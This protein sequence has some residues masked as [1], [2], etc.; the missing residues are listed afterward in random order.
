MM[1]AIFW[2]ELI[3][4]IALSAFF[5]GSEMAFS[6]VNRLRLEGA[7]EHG[8]KRAKLALRIYD[9]FESTLSA[10]LIGNNLVNIASSSTA[11]VMAIT[12]FGVGST[13]WV[14]TLLTITIIIFGETMPKIVAKKNATRLC[15]AISYPLYLVMIV[16]SPVV[17]VVVWLTDRITGLFK[18]EEKDDSAGEEE[19]ATIIKTVEDE[20]VIDNDRSEL[21]QA[22]LDFGDTSARDVMTARVDVLALDIEDDW[23]EQLATIESSS[24]SRLPVY[25]D[26][27][28]NVIGVLYL[29]HFF[30]AMADVPKGASVDIRSLL[31]KPCYVYKTVKLPSVLAEMRRAKTHLAI[32]TDDYGGTTGIVTMEDVLEEIVGEIWDETDVV[33]QDLVERAE[34]L[35][36]IEGDM[37]IDEFLELVGREDAGFETEADTVGGWTLEGFGGFPKENDT[38]ERDG[39]HITVL[40]MD[41]LRVGKVLIKVLTDEADEDDDE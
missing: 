32:V 30:K 29:N 20:G 13:A 31:V 17:Y 39:F 18:G 1:D 2:I 35:Y 5:S 19:L 3:A 40:E 21:L 26:S 23:E 10:I 16:F 4:L 38:L 6:S 11:T 33:E 7:A 12:L 15:V 22:A 8:S 24:F 14:N 27:M 28:D 36:E 25:E 37:N 34:D 9:R 41:G